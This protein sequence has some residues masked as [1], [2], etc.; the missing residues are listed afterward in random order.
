MHEKRRA[1]TLV[2]S[3][4]VFC[5]SLATIF[6]LSG[7]A[8]LKPPVAAAKVDDGKMEMT[9]RFKPVK[10][11]EGKHFNLSN[12]RTVSAKQENKTG[13]V[14][15]EILVRFKSDQVNV[16][17]F[18][19][20]GSVRKI[21]SLKEGSMI[22]DFAKIYN[23]EKK[24][25]LTRSNAVVFKIKDG[26]N[27]SQK[28]DSLKNDSRVEHAQP[29]FKYGFMAVSPS[30]DTY[31]QDQWALHN[32]GQTI[33]VDGEEY[34]GTADADIDAPEAWAVSEGDGSIRVAIIDTGVG[35]NHPDL[36]Q[37]MWD[38]SSC[39]DENDDVIPGGCVYGYD[40]DNNDTDPA[41]DDHSYNTGVYSHGT[42]IAG[43]IAGVDNDQGIVG[44]D[45][46][47]KIMA[48]K[49]ADLTTEEIVKGIA[50]AENNG[51]KIINASWGG[52]EDD[53]IL[54]TAINEFDG[55]FIAAAGNDWDDNDSDPTYPCSFNLENVICVAATDENDEMTYWS[56]YGEESVDVGAPGSIIVSS[57]SEGKTI[58]QDFEDAVT[59]SLPIEF[60]KSEGS[61]WQTYDVTDV[62][63][64]G[65][66]KF[67]DSWRNVIYGDNLLPYS[68]S[69]NTDAS[70]D[71]I[72]L[73]G[74]LTVEMEFYT[75]CDTE[76]DSKDWH[77]YMSLEV[78]SDGGNNWQE[79]VK[80][81]EA[82]LKNMNWDLSQAGYGLGYASFYV[83]PEF[84]TDNF[85]FRFRWVT[86]DDNNNFG[87]CLVDDVILNVFNDGTGDGYE[88]WDGTSMAA[89]Q[90]AGLA[91][92]I[93][94]TENSLSKYLVKD[95]VLMT[96]DNKS[97]LQGS[98]V[99]GK[100]INAYNAVNKAKN[101][102]AAPTVT[103][104]GDGTYD[105]SI[106]AGQTASLVFSESISTKEARINVENAIVNELSD[107]GFPGNLDW[108]WNTSQNTMTMT[109]VGY[110]A[111]F[112]NDVVADVEDIAGNVSSGLLLIDSSADVTP[113]TGSIR[114]NNNASKTTRKYVT[115]NLNASDVG[116]TVYKMM[117]SNNGTLWSPW[118]AYKATYSN[119]NMTS[120]AYGGNSNAGTKK[121]YVKFQDRAGNISAKYYD[122]ITYSK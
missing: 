36:N 6:S 121:V 113:P 19:N 32:T 57:V 62:T 29:N 71:V 80:W 4:S 112:K 83:D 24:A 87:G 31:Y 54:E 23:L 41:P 102:S 107:S 51:A 103:K 91:A 46:H 21:E 73:S 10:E 101:D 105:Y 38:G 111:T 82:V 35:Y 86:D 22:R 109:A 13:Y 96:G 20:T 56:N 81:D 49:T 1:K 60:T 98:T 114:I 117:F 104:K 44:V 48:V 40:Y 122:T 70:S 75:A 97:T 3:A 17:R 43:I 61:N 5:L 76:F 118:Y 85:K 37:N 59:P 34:T 65:P 55:L 58:D 11:S 26:Q 108:S 39:V 110:N 47:T 63:I 106:S 53:E 25:V 16:K 2:K 78:S 79:S 92:L 99:S 95:L 84:F 14:E 93:W 115:L 68:D 9:N 15:D 28:I 18:L 45:P 30:D 89:P 119:W 7:G 69:V 27:V 52:S 74:A 100:R 12:R 8:L 50:F 120:S 77:D 66:Y 64:Q 94:E 42:H 116:G 90:V 72:D 67:G 33:T 88:Y